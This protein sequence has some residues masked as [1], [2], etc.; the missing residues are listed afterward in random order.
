VDKFQL[1]INGWEIV[2]AYS[3]LVDPVDQE[4][5]F[6][7]QTRN[8]KKGEEEVMEIDHEYLKTMSYGMPP[9]SGFGLG[10]DRLVAL[11]LGKLNLR[12]V[13]LFPLL[14]PEDPDPK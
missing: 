1:V 7:E 8:K 12:D 13:A 11:L 9:I 6:V 4:E 5:R 3:E 14:R 2:K 10:I